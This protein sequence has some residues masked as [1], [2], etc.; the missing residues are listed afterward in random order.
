MFS[1][2]SGGIFRCNMGN[3][4]IT[5]VDPAAN[6]YAAAMV[7]DSLG[8]STPFGFLYVAPSDTSSGSD[9]DAVTVNAGSLHAQTLSLGGT[10]A[11]GLRAGRAR[12]GRVHWEPL[13][14]NSNSYQIIQTGNKPV[15]IGEVVVL[16]DA[17][18]SNGFE[19]VFVLDTNNQNAILGPV[20]GNATPNTNYISINADPAGESWYFGPSSHI[21][22]DHGGTTEGELR[23]LTSAGTGNG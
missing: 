14:K 19:H 8:N 3:W 20:Q 5:S 22:V 17:Q 11:T 16:E 1:D 7:F 23:S 2:N 6:D 18:T 10:V 15:I 12:I 9:V 21:N 4:F 13:G